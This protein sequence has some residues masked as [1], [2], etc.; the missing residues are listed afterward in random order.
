MVGWGVGG[1]RESFPHFYHDAKGLL[2]GIKCYCNFHEIVN[3]FAIPVKIVMLLCVVCEE[4][5][6]FVVW[7]G[8]RPIFV[9]R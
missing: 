4:C 7:D 9:C 5:T 3:L 6:I 1:G 2:G 8:A